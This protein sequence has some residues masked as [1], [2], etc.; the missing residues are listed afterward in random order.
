M[1]FGLSYELLGVA[2]GMLVGISLD[3]TGG[4]GSIFAVPLPL[5]LSCMP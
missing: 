1:D 3:L 2:F 5:I 4:G